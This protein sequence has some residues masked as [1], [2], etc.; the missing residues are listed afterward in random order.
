VAGGA[1]GT[2]TIVDYGMGNLASVS[3]AL[4]R[5]GATP[6]V[7]ADPREVERAERLIVPG[8]GAFG[9]A[10]AELARRRLIEPI[11]AFAARGRPL[12][13]I[14]LGMQILMETSEEAPGVD[15]L[16][17]VPGRVKLLRVAEKVPHMGW[18]TVARVRPAPL[19][20]G[21]P[22]APYVY[23]VHSYYVAPTGESED[24][25]AGRTTHGIE[26]ASVLWQGNVQ[27]TQFHPEKS[28]AL[29]LRILNNFLSS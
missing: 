19:L 1:N 24:A 14:C 9:D 20:R 28:Q 21:L 29:G 2:I 26:F 5:L 23:F 22:D 16:G 7:T 25:V 18:N 11:L 15:G 27:A 13:G 17:L 6:R 10:M 3:K 8:V 12:L 4:D